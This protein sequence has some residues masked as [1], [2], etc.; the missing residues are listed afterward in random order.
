MCAAAIRSAHAD[1]PVTVPQTI[2]ALRE[3]SGCSGWRLLR[4]VAVS[5]MHQGD[6][7]NGSYEQLIDA[8]SGRYVTHWHSGDFTS[9]DGYDG[10]APWERDFS[11]TTHVMDA[12][13]AVAIAKTEAWVRARGWCDADSAEYAP[14]E[15][16][17]SANGT[18]L[19][20]VVA[21]PAAGASVTLSIDR[22]THLLESSSVRYDENHLV[23][24]YT[25]W[26]SVAGTMVPY[27]TSI[28][29]PEDND[30]EQ[31]KIEG[32]VAQE[33]FE[34][35]SSAYAPPPT[36]FGISMPAGA[37]AVIVPY[38]MEGYKP[39]VEVTID[40]KGPFPF[41]VDA[42][43]H[44]IVTAGTAR[45]AGLQGRGSISSTNQ[46][47]VSH[48]GFAHVRSIGIG[49]AVLR[50]EVAEIN[51]YSFAKLE[52]GPRPPKAG[53]LGLEFF[54]RFAV[55]FDPRRHAMTLR[56]LN[57]ARPAA[58]GT[59]VPIV[60]DADSPLA[61]CSIAG[62][63]GSCMLDTG[64]AAP[65]IVASRWANR[66]GVAS[67]LQRG[68]FVG[69]G[70]YVSRVPVSL[71]PFV[72]SREVV[73]YEPDP[74][75]ELYT[76]EAAILSEAFIDG[77]VST[78]DYARRGVWLEPLRRGPT[79][80][81]R[82]GVIAAKQPGGEFIV[83]YV[84]AGSPAVSAGLRAGDVITAIDGVSAKRFSG[85]DFATANASQKTSI[86]F[87]VVRNGSARTVVVRK[88]DLAEV[89]AGRAN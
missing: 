45:Y 62:K 13:S 81:N 33:S 88:R 74:D 78:F 6:N 21:R 56:P 29:D 87:T 63:S 84:I 71:G 49:G 8:R 83:R 10:T 7:L 72:R 22:A 4:A 41:V 48:V 64:N 86:A 46:R 44:F 42:G 52:R 38:V 18:L 54:E 60:F 19:D 20:A 27:V 23:Q 59:K 57:V 47:T 43:G 66:A 11:G 12:P 73:M 39:I 36:S 14:A 37:K 17:Q 5:G 67:V 16:Q 53:W 77:F 28:V 3:A 82:S 69:S 58:A 76:V 61:N 40:G 15:T 31:R 24:Y 50:G 25:D 68:L 70:T 89:L 65:V 34:P 51:P 1:A 85:A 80:Y 35:P 30:I 55:T 9:G 26:R 79:P 2:A 32:F 75:A